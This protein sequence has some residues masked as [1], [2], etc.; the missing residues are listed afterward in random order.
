[1]TVPVDDFLLELDQEREQRKEK[2]FWK[3]QLRVSQFQETAFDPTQTSD[4]FPNP[5]STPATP[6]SNYI[7]PV[8]VE[9]QAHEKQFLA[10]VES[11][12]HSNRGSL[13]LAWIYEQDPQDL[14]MLGKGFEEIASLVEKQYELQQLHS[15]FEERVQAEVQQRVDSQQRSRRVFRFASLGLIG[16]EDPDREAIEKEVRESLLGNEHADK[17]K[18]EVDERL[19]RFVDSNPE[20]TEEELSS[21]RFRLETLFEGQLAQGVRP[22]VVF[23]ETTLLTDGLDFLT[24]GLSGA[25]ELGSLLVGGLLAAGDAVL[26]ASAI[27]PKDF[28]EGRYADRRD[29]MAEQLE[30]Q[31][32]LP[33]TQVLADAIHLP[34]EQA[35]AELDRTR[36]EVKSQYL[37]MASGDPNLA[38]GLFSQE[39]Q[40]QPEVEEQLANV[41]DAV[42]Q[43]DRDLLRQL[44]ESDF[45]VSDAVLDAIATYGREVPM[46]LSTAF[47]LLVSEEDLRSGVMRGHFEDL[48][49]EVEKNDFSPAKVFD[50]QGTAAGLTLDLGAGIAFD[51]TT[52][53][54]GPKGGARTSRIA[55]LSQVDDV[56][57]SPL[58]Q[59][60]LKDFERIIKSP[61]KGNVQAVTL[62]SWLDEVGLLDDALE[63]VGP[64]SKVFSGSPWLDEYADVAQEMQT[65]SLLKIADDSKIAGAA[66]K[67][68]SGLKTS[69]ESTGFSNPVVLGYSQADDAVFLVDGGKRIVA[70]S[71]LGA[72]AVPTT[73]K[74]FD[75]VPPN[76]AATKLDDLLSPG[77][78]RIIPE[79]TEDFVKP[80]SFLPDE[81]VLGATKFDE[82]EELFKTALKRGAYPP[83]LNRG[84]VANAIAS[85][86]KNSLKTNPITKA[87]PVRW[88]QKYAT[89]RMTTTRLPLHG[90][91]AMKGLNEQIMQI[92]GDDL[93]TAETYLTRVR[94]S[95]LAEK[96]AF[97]A[98]TTEY[99]VIGALKK[100]IDVLRDTVGSSV[101]DQARLAQFQ[102]AAAADFIRDHRFAQ[103][104]RLAQLESQYTRRIHKV[105]GELE[106]L[107]NRDA[108]ADT[109]SE[110][111]D[112]WNRRNI[113]TNPFWKKFVNEDGIVPWEVIRGESGRPAASVLEDTRKFVPE[114]KLVGG[115]L[116]AFGDA[117]ETLRALLKT[118]DVRASVDLPVSP[119]EMFLASNL[120][121]AAYKRAT[122]TWLAGG[123]REFAWSAQRM[124]ILDKVM[125]P[126]TGIVVSFDEMSR[127][128]HRYGAHSM[129]R[130]LEDKALFTAAR[131]K[132]V[133]QKGRL[134]L[135]ANS[136]LGERTMR[137][138]QALESYPSLLK[139]AERQV[140]ESAG[141]GWDDVAVGDFGFKGAAQQWTGLHLQDA[142]FRS[143]LRGKDNFLE[144]VNS[145]DGAH[146]AAQTVVDPTTGT[147]RLATAEE[148]YQG[149]ETLFDTLVLRGSADKTKT[150]SVW[151]DAAASV[152]SSGGVTKELPLWALEELGTVR[153]VRRLPSAN[154]ITRIQT[155]VGDKLFLDPA[156]YR[157]GFI[158]EL[159]RKTEKSRLERLFADQGLEIIPESKLSE[160][161]GMKGLDF[162]SSPALRD[163]L[164]ELALRANI[165]PEGYIDN[166]IENRVAEEVDALLYSWDSS[167]R[168]GQQGRVVFPFGGPWAD[169]WGHWGREVVSRPA[170][171]GYIN[172]TSFANIGKMANAVTDRSLVNWRSTA[173][174]SRLANQEFKI[175]R[176]LAGEGGGLLP[177]SEETDFSPLFFLPVAGE[178]PFFVSLPGM[179][180][181]P[182]AAID[183]ILESIDPVE[184]PEEYRRIVDSIADFIPPVGFQQGG[185]P[186]R[187]AGGGNFAA[188]LSLLQDRYN[189][190]TGKPFFLVSNFFG[191]ITREV[192]RGRELNALLSDPEEF[193]ELISLQDEDAV[194]LAL[195][196]LARQADINSANASSAETISRLAIPANNEYDTALDQIHRVWTDA[197][198]KFPEL[199]VRPD[200]QGLDLDDPETLRQYAAD[201]RSAFFDLPSWKRDLLVAQQPSLAVNLVGSWEWTEF[202]VS[203]RVTGT[204]SPYR[205]GGSTEDLALHQSLVERGYVRP[206][207]PLSKAYVI[208]GIA[209]EA[210]RKS[211]KRI[212][213]FQAERVN[214]ALW[215][216]QVTA[217]T[218]KRL[219]Q[220]AQLDILKELNVADG[221]DLWLRWGSLEGDFEDAIIR[222]LNI[223]PDSD[224]AEFIRSDGIKVPSKEKA[225]GTSWPGLE[226]TSERFA[227]VKFTEF[228]PEIQELAAGLDIELTPGMTGLQLFGDLQSKLTE[229]ET[230]L[231]NIVRASYDTYISERGQG[232]NTQLT[233]LNEQQYNP[234]LDEDW[235]AGLSNFL[236][237]EANV[238]EK[239]AADGFLSSS[240]Q[241]EVRDRYNTLVA[242]ASDLPL[243]WNN[244]WEQGF[245]R[246]YG[247]RDWT[248][249]EPP[250][251]FN[252]DG[253]LGTNTWTP[254]I[255]RVVDGDTLWVSDTPGA[256]AVDLPGLHV[257]SE[258]SKSRMHAVRLIGVNAREFS[259]DE[260]GASEDADRLRD[261]LNLALQNGDRVYLVRDPDNFGNTDHFGRELAWLYIGD[262]AWYFEDDFKATN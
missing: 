36:P 70:A 116:T 226:K 140:L 185:V 233:I 262:E 30:H 242:T 83:S 206:V 10:E 84:I 40:D 261:A 57:K 180:V 246:N 240:D 152:D 112:E 114:E 17:I 64:E 108:I 158:A 75:S 214:E 186:S 143:F 31:L 8:V 21:E 49:T 182:L 221:K 211:A 104:Q 188:G 38:F 42:R 174:L 45:R 96:A 74:I 4:V 94:E 160:S 136:R 105:Q 27:T 200:L 131:A 37:S 22:E 165:V 14:K 78:A 227:S 151:K 137:R 254:F 113:A 139:S 190:A 244:I 167:S 120:G 215:S 118:P 109:I 89:Q 147:T 16:V 80:G 258:G 15:E 7:A 128:F 193:A 171:R 99:Q 253:S 179:G 111:Y 168:L 231:W 144:F 142:G 63:L 110:M 149:M 251:A 126:S 56:I 39:V 250:P 199:S 62:G 209:N 204:D 117:E 172:D 225:W 205:T 228:S 161:L 69:L 216:S 169:M 92:W 135:G 90:P 65:S 52:W 156:N 124:W 181:L 146:M 247:D 157:R 159:V 54:F 210:K 68:I 192:N 162:Q 184:N 81:L 141:T 35:W 259:A 243:A 87:G 71:D 213:E 191:D 101:D 155:T 212:Y 245:E 32:S 103:Q 260:E 255:R 153:G 43:E 170:L 44:D 107:P 11:V 217:E 189:A 177:G 46:R 79:L 82:L 252:E 119:L 77:D 100:E 3:Q 121:G 248:P 175:D 163:H 88:L 132:S 241:Q 66:S 85:S 236:T 249:P 223:D 173:F 224:Q 195:E 2:A 20:A 48:W 28:L 166:L 58:L 134:T 222:E 220:F 106:A 138:L 127:V 47:G 122:Q 219:E 148:L 125:R 86:L 234:A 23:G 257:P 256:F 232:R 207:D 25:A 51:P 187:L 5:T 91:Q 208:L 176:G 9:R 123:V 95:M 133:L 150:L 145:P 237:F 13:P 196:G 6:K 41:I 72:S 202:A 53:I 29:E 229:T 115:E 164:N 55:S 218:K 194:R 183:R 34:I 61:S 178:N 50:L 59:R 33:D 24:T 130:W 197:A 97:R 239:A 18:S 201:V 60:T 26:P 73:V 198:N 203:D 129:G 93:A 235:R 98:A 238:R 102:D 230:P 12:F 1:M 67:D 154:P 76:T 19:T